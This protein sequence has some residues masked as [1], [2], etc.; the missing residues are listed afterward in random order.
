MAT[1]FPIGGDL[2]RRLWLVSPRVMGYKLAIKTL[3]IVERGTST[4][5]CASNYSVADGIVRIKEG[6]TKRFFGAGWL[7]A[8]AD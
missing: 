7:C 6:C 2:A 8:L 4:V 3:P 5:R 1:Q